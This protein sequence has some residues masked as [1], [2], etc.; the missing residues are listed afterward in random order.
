[1]SHRGLQNCT[2]LIFSQVQ[3]FFRSFTL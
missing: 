3:Y 1:M 2:W